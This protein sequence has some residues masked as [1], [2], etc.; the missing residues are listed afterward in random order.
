MTRS[1]VVT[2]PAPS[3]LR[4]RVSIRTTWGCCS[5]SSAAS[6]IV[7]TRS[8]AGMN[9]ESAFSSVVLPLAGPAR[10][11]DVDPGPD[12]R[13]EEVDHLLGDRPLGD[14]VLE[15]SS[16]L[17]P[18]RR[19]ETR[20][21][22]SARGGMIALTRLPSGSRASTIGMVSST[23]RPTRLTMRWT[24]WSRCFSSLKTTSDRDQP[25][26]ALD[27]DRLRSVDQD[28]GDRRVPDQRFERTQAERLVE[29]LADEPLALAQVEQVELFRQSDSAAW[30]TSTR[31][32]SSSIA[33][34]AERSMPG[35]QLLVQLAS[36]SGESGLRQSP[37]NLEQLVDPQ[38]M[39]LMFV[40]PP[41]IGSDSR[42][43][44]GK[45]GSVSHGVPAR[46]GWS[47][48]ANR[49]ARAVD[50]LAALT[51][52]SLGDRPEPARRGRQVGDSAGVDLHQPGGTSRPRP[53]G[54]SP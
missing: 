52:V 24:I 20:V 15:L 46:L 27:V 3:M 6:S 51:D 47:S 32:S 36:C 29:H 42:R 11:Q 22:S 7:A 39:R 43:L 45:S 28:V 40:Y 35:D 48:S 5:R 25:A 8:S 4:G 13:R 9:P 30:R 44:R 37:P 2:S 33:P 54:S 12:A 41:L 17:A 19:I 49:C 23:R 53:A 31:S 21:P 18:N 34:I 26:L 1:R 38:L 10:D 50:R 14:Q 16:G